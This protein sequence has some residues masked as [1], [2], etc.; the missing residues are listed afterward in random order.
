M[1][2]FFL[3]H[4]VCK[5]EVF[6]AKQNKVLLFSL[7]YLFILSV[8]PLLAAMPRA[9]IDLIVTEEK[10]GKYFP[11]V[12]VSGTFEDESGAKK[13]LAEK[14]TDIR[15]QYEEFVTVN[16]KFILTVSAPG[17]QTEIVE[18]QVKGTDVK[19][20]RRIRNKITLKR[21]VIKKEE[22]KETPL[23]QEQKPP[24][25]TP[26]T[27]TEYSPQIETIPYSPPP[28]TLGDMTA[29]T[30]WDKNR[31]H[32]LALESLFEGDIHF[33]YVTRKLCE[34][35]LTHQESFLKGLLEI[36]KQYVLSK[37]FSQD[38]LEMRS[39]WFG[40]KDNVEDAKVPLS[41]NELIKKRLQ[42]FLDESL[43]VDFNAE[44]TSKDCWVVFVKEDYEKKSKIWKKCYRAGP[45]LTKIARDFATDLLN[46]LKK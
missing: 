21:A 1:Q 39:N 17:Y 43:S 13:D 35:T 40:I 28:M 38:Y 41:V 20:S 36:A 5:E 23:I 15:G 4:K 9:V 11:N 44:T 37:N 6:M 34:A 42:W 18:G 24:A 32:R 29:E 3:T 2:V 12:K 46:T 30:G 7:L 31:I 19:V 25:I 45:R 16:G 22:P 14:N 10:S 8:S 27:Q 33:G 26:Q